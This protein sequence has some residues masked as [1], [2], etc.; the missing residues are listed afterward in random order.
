MS[1]AKDIARDMAFDG[2]PGII[3]GGIGAVASRGAMA[4]VSRFGTSATGRKLIPGLDGGLAG[5][6]T[7]NPSYNTL[8][9]K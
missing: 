8:N 4:A 7:E 5:G 9:G 1:Q 6:G 3:G 2:I